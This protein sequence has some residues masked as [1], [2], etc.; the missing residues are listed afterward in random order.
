MDSVLTWFLLQSS[1][2]VISCRLCFVFARFNTPA[3]VQIHHDTKDRKV[4]IIHLIFTQHNIWKSKNV[5]GCH[6]SFLS[7]WEDHAWALFK[8][9]AFHF[10][11]NVRELLYLICSTWGDDFGEGRSCMICSSA[12]K[13][14]N[15]VQRVCSAHPFNLCLG[16]FFIIQVPLRILLLIA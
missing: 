10:A 3:E 7:L 9:Q 15:S 11:M 14:T 12:I 5:W 2:E 6:E 4:L 8:E 16:T 13:Y 1:A